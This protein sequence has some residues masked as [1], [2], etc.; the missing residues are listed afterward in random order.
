MVQNEATRGGG[1]GALR[2]EYMAENAI[3]LLDQAGPQGKI[4]LWA[5]NAH[6]QNLSPWMGAHLRSRYGAEYVILGFSFYQGGFNA[7][8]QNAAGQFL[9]LTALAAPPA[10]DGSI[11]HHFQRLDR[12]RVLLDL[13]PLRANR[14]A[15]AAWLR[16][17]LPLR[18]IGAVYRPSSPAAYFAPT[19][20]PEQYDVMIHFEN[21]TPSVLLPFRYE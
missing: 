6:V 9:R 16:G 10:L 21:T 20:V 17:P 12:P 8:E 2:D 3:W 18:N 4:V 15:S 14:S 1:G 11:E 5:H 7:I 13:R 19:R